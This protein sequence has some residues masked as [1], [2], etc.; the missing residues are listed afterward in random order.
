MPRCLIWELKRCYYLSKKSSNLIRELTGVPLGKSISLTLILQ[1]NI[2]TQATGGDDANTILTVL[3][4]RYKAAG[5]NMVD[6]SGEKDTVE[7]W[8]I[9]KN[10]A[11]AWPSHVHRTYPELLDRNMPTIIRPFVQK[12]LNV[13]ETVLDIF[14]DRLGL[15]KGTLE[16]L[17]PVEE[18]S[19]CEARIIKNPPMPHNDQKRGIGAHTDFGSLVYSF[20]PYSPRSRM[21]D[22]RQYR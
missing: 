16:S 7:F 4:L 11:L 1:E 8:N 18:P 5:S 15:P 6:A 2:S 22:P 21:T 12:S 13:N 19:G 14:N 3:F 20:I 17:H 10:D 9:S